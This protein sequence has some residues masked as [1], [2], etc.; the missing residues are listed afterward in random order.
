VVAARLFGAAD[1]LRERVGVA[2]SWS[3]DPT[4]AAAL[5]TVRAS[6][7]EK[8]FEP[9]WAAGRQ[10]SAEDAIASAFA[11][12]RDV[13]AV[14]VVP[15]VS[16]AARLTSREREV[17]ALIPLGLSNRQIA[18]RLVIGERTVESHVSHLLAKLQLPSRTRL[19]S[20]AI[21]AGL[22]AAPAPELAR[23]PRPSPQSVPGTVL[24]RTATRVAAA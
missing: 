13:E 23:S 10:L 4:R 9:A 24:A 14:P 11:D 5:D 20:W 2:A 12:T 15:P 7:G 21:E 3:L 19:A 1:A 16:D 18:E 17:A 8:R 6:L 22:T